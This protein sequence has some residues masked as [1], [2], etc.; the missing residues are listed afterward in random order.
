[1]DN[2]TKQKFCIYSYN[3]RGSS[4]D[5]LNYIENLIS[6]SGD[7]IPIFCIQE[8]FLLRNSLRKLSS[9]FT[10]SSVL[11]KPAFKDFNIQVRGRA[12]GGLAIIVPK[13]LRK[14]VKIISCDS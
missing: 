13:T 4:Q 12:K 9:F 10:A 14:N 8:H 2:T 1:M 3:S 11:A 7:K 6:L 5:K